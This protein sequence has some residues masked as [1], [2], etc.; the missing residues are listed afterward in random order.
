M[1]RDYT[2]YC[3]EFYTKHKKYGICHKYILFPAEAQKSSKIIYKL[4]YITKFG[5]NKKIFTIGIRYTSGRRGKC[6]IG[7]AV[8]RDEVEHFRTS[9][10]LYADK[11]G[12]EQQC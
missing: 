7:W 1:W 10:L 3:M 5:H 11:K 2:V 12:D 9:P 4:H 6:V 8:E